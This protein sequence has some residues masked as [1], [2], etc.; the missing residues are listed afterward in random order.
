MPTRTYT[1]DE[2]NRLLSDNR[3]E[4]VLSVTLTGADT[5]QARIPA[6]STTYGEAAITGNIVNYSAN[7]QQY[8]GDYVSK[9]RVRYEVRLY[10]VRTGN[11]AWVA[12]G[13]ITPF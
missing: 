5:T 3:I 8:G 1:N 2:F 13:S 9:P 4:G 10:D 11:T 6:F 12:T 7:T